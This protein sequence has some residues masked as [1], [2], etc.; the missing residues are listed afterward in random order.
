ME[1]APK[2]LARQK[3]VVRKLGSISKGTLGCAS[4]SSMVLWGL[5]RQKPFRQRMEQE[6][7]QID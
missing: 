5:G 1:D 3:D 6:M 2:L 7:P 4:R